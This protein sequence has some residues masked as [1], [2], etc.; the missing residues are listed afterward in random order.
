MLNN[1]CENDDK[2]TLTEGCAAVVWIHLPCV[3]N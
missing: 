1:E 2:S 3:E